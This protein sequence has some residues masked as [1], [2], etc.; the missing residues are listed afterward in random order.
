RD[1]D[2]LRLYIA[3]N[4]AAC[5]TV[6]ECF[7]NLPSN[8]DD[9]GER[10]PFADEVAEMLPFHIRHDEKESAGIDAD[11]VGDDD[12]GMIELRNQSRFTAEALFGIAGEELMR[13][14]F[15]R[16]VAI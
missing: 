7:R 14:D 3:M 1:E 13:N 10:R 4:D 12:A 9:L 5:M 11:V 6:I 16:N 15:D 2:V 8:L